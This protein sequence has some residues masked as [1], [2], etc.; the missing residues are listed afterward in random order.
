MCLDRSHFYQ[1]YLQRAQTRPHSSLF[2]FGKEMS[3]PS[4]ELGSDWLKGTFKPWK[5]EHLRLPT[6][7]SL[8]SA[9]SLVP[10]GSD[11]H[12]VSRSPLWC[13]A[14]ASRNNVGIHHRR[15]LGHRLKSV[16][17]FYYEVSDYSR[18]LG[19]QCSPEHVSGWAFK[20][21]TMSLV[22]AVQLTRTVYKSR[23]TEA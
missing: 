8:T 16:E 18:C 1:T 22:N 4:E 3:D 10:R 7:S 14:G 12:S 9:L 23:T 17:N 2:T 20:H 15:L 6:R 11:L 13:F 19:S 5:L 21:Q